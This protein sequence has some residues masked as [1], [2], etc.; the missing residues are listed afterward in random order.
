[1]SHART[2]PEGL[3]AIDAELR[4]VEWIGHAPPERPLSSRAS[5]ALDAAL[6]VVGAGLGAALYLFA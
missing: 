1:M 4:E 2:I 3:Q 5:A 6:V